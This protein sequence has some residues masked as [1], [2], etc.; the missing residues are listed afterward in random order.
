MRSHFEMLARVKAL[1]VAAAAPADVPKVKRIP[2]PWPASDPLTKA[3]ARVM[4]KLGGWPGPG[5]P[6]AV[7]ARRP[8]GRPAAGGSRAGRVPLVAVGNL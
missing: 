6:L 3:V 2:W 5:D 7:P 1:A 4:D 8:A